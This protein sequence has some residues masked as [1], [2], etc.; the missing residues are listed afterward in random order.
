[1]AFGAGSAD[2]TSTLDPTLAKIYR[3]IFLDTAQEELIMKQ[4]CRQE[5]LEKNHGKTVNWPR[6]RTQSAVTAA[7][8]EG[9][10]PTEQNM[11]AQEIEATVEQW[12]GVFKPTDFFSDTT[13]D[14]R[15]EEYIEEVAQQQA[16]T[17]DLLIATEQALEGGWPL[18]AGNDSTYFTTGTPA[19]GGVDTCTDAE[20]FTLLTTAD[21]FNGGRFH[22]LAKDATNFGMTRPIDDYTVSDPNGTISFSD[23]YGIGVRYPSDFPAAV[24]TTD[25]YLVIATKNLSATDIIATADLKRARRALTWNRAKHFT[26]GFFVMVV[27]PDVLYDISSDSTWVDLQKYKESERGI[28]KH[29]VGKLWGIK[30]VEATQPYRQAVTDYSYS[31]SG[32][33]HVVPIFGKQAIAMAELSSQSQQMIFKKP[34][35]NDTSNPLNMFSTVGWKFAA[36]AKVLNAQYSVN[37]FCGATA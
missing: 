33:V 26:G 27:D 37:I 34:G 19:S 6:Y 9:E 4:F 35:K 2:T 23:D 18:L 5:K 25:D 15:L 17:Y 13:R 22:V 8:T 30:V 14:T 1:M 21:D 20:F 24:D 36:A 7:L 11:A 29:E 28:F 10:N 31:E 32:A 3:R 12:G 16:L